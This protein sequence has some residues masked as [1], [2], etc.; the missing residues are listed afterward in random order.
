MK[1]H[2]AIFRSTAFAVLMA[3]AGGAMAQVTSVPAQPD[4]SV[5]GEASTMTP[6]GVANPPQRPDNSLPASRE[7]VKAEARTQNRNNAN[8][9]VPKGEATTTV[10]HQPNAMPQPTGEM[11]RMEVSQQARKVKPQFGQKGERPEV[12]TNPTEKTGTPQ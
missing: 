12:P 5:G 4:P 3:A 6:A 9:M 11:S 8:S 10:N 1:Q 2:T 7:A